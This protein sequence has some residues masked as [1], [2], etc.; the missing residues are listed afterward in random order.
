MNIIR[1]ILLTAVTVTLSLTL[2]AQAQIN[3]KKVKI[4][5]FPTKTTKVVLTGNEIFDTYIKSDVN[6]CWRISPYEFCDI[7]E[8]N[9]IKGSSDYYF[10]M[11]TKGQFRRETEP[12]L[13]FITLVKGGDG[14][15]KGLASM[16]EIVCVPFRSSEDPSGRESEFIP[17]FLDIIQK[18]TLDS[19][20]KDI[21]GY[22]GLSNTSINLPKA[23]GKNIVFADEDLSSQIDE[24]TKKALF[25]KYMS[26][27]DID[28]ADALL[29]E[30]DPNTVISFSIAPTNPGKGSYCYKM[31]INAG[32]HELY[33]Y[34]KHRIS[35]KAGAGFLSEDIKRIAVNTK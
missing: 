7:D 12:G 30:A 22:I 24:A 23:K 11:F 14:A 15:D 4:A 35:A 21:D 16:L 18:Y 6:S 33:Y 5:D 20:E 9:K 26:V 29:D 17:V 31:L 27:K 1:R 2:S 13:D 25:N 8:F 19:I 10:L 34:R 32:T 28:D 3:T